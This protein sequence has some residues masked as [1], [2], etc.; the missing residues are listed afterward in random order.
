MQACLRSILVLIFLS[1]L[2]SCNSLTYTPRS[3]KNTRKE[4]PSVVLLN[5]LVQFR[6]QYNA[7]PFTKEEFMLK[8]QAFK[9]AFAGFPYKTT[10]FRVIDNNT[11]TFYFSEHTRDLQQYEQ[12]GK[13]ELNAY[14]GEVRFYLEKD[15]FI[16]KLKM[17]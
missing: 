17:Y 4:K 3:K 5:R 10:V 14:A 6:E 15:K 9:D 8:S 2:F 7:W 12:T 1:G 13:T 16:W 11:M